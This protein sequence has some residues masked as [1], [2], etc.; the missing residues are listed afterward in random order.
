M[1]TIIDKDKALELLDAAVAAEGEDKT[2]LECSYFEGD[3]TTPNCIVGHALSQV[4]AKL[5]D[6][7][8]A[9]AEAGLARTQ[10]AMNGVGVTALSVNGMEITPEAMHIFDVAQTV[11]DGR[12]HDEWDRS[13]GNAVRR[14]HLTATKPEE[15]QA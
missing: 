9:D 10:F 13:W 14:A 3:G 15:E 8:Y 6:L 12:M 5:A 4:G 11:Q 1:T 2:A 7:D